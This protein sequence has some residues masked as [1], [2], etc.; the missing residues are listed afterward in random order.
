VTSSARKKTLSP[1]KHRHDG[2]SP[3]PLGM[4]WNPPWLVWLLISLA[5]AG[6]Q[7]VLGARDPEV[8]EL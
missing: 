7:L 6:A 5:D 1:P 4:E 8:V 3:L 2:T